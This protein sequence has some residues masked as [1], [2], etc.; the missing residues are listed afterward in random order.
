MG[1]ILSN[2]QAAELLLKQNPPD[3]ELIGTILADICK[4]DQRA[5]EVITHLR[6][7][8]KKNDREPEV[9]NFNDVVTLAVEILAP[10]A[11]SRGITLTANLSPQPLPARVNPVHLQQVI[12]NLVLNG[13]DATT[14]RLPEDSKVTI[15]TSA[16][17]N[18]KIK[19]SIMD[20]GSGIPPDKLQQIFDPFFT[21]KEQGTGL[22]LAIV[23]TIVERSGGEISADNRPTGGAVFHFSLPLVKELVA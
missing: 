14:G 16:I 11:K 18:A 7:L 13:M 10:E 15:R 23:R 1:A 9:V 5:G 4:S 8:L 12:L 3:L 6:D 17:Q 22:G 19:V 20:S 2:A 21:T